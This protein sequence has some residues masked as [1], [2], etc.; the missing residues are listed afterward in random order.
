M[1]R[2]AL[3]LVLIGVLFRFWAAEHA[4][5]TGDE[6]DYW[7]RSL[8]LARLQEIPV[9]GPE[10]TGSEAHLPG[11]AYYYLMAIPQS[12]GVSPRWGAGFVVLLHG[13][14]G[15]L[16]FLVARAARGERAGILGLVLW[17]FAPWDV[18][19][20]DR[21]WGSCV[22]PV[23]GTLA[24]YGALRAKERPAWQGVVL[25]LC[26]VLP[27][28]HL[29][30]PVLWLA[31]LVIVL[32]RRPEKWSKW[33]L[34]VGLALAV[35][36]Y[37]P[38]LSSELR[39]D[40]ANFRTMLAKS[41]GAEP[42]EV[43]KKLPSQ[44][45]GYAVGYASAEI[46]YHFNRGYWGGGF[47]DWA[48]Y[49]SVAGWKK[50]A[51]FHGGW[52]PL[53]AISLLLA[54]WG[55]MAA[56]V[57]TGRQLRQATQDKTPV[58]LEAVLTLAIL[59]G[60]AVGVALM[61]GAK[62]RYF[63]H[64]ANILMPLALWPVV[65]SLD[66][67][68]AKYRWLVGPA[69]AAS[70]LVMV[71]NCIR[72]YTQIDALNGLGPTLAM[73]DRVTQ[74]NGPVNLR[75]SHFYNQY[76]WAMLAENLYRRPLRV[77]ARAPVSFTVNNHAPHDGPIPPGAA[78]F[79]PVL[80]TRTPPQ[81]GLLE[82]AARKNW[83]R[84]KISTGPTGVE[85][86]CVLDGPK[87]RYGAQPWQYFGP[88]NLEIGGETRAILFMHP[89]AGEVVRAQWPVDKNNLRGVLRYGLSDA[90]AQSNNTDPVALHLLQGDRTLARVQAGNNPG[91]HD[92]PFV[93][94]TTAA[95]VLELR[96]QNDGARVF[97]FDLEVEPNP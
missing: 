72:Y 33:S 86:P 36:I 51:N 49:G 5:F 87:C 38:P 69:L 60:L 12:F 32:L 79:G 80:L 61:M 56:L 82:S 91:F 54:L 62:K 17:M 1:R 19:Y 48:A 84:W 40:F 74:E 16:L 85:R 26:L 43:V 96:S 97:A 88:E 27:Q 30:V 10:I 23:W 44:V 18:L 59:V 29:S 77:E 89:I 46:G 75:F 53:L 4:R 52:A 14:C 66:A 94:T 93:L 57:R 7:A 58:R 20:A 64:Y 35:L 22:V 15:F 34:G 90:A 76:A 9:Y 3:F 68:W 2:W 67:A 25:F 71:A 13:L 21:I 47:D 78:T 73:V 28:L 37:L 39:H 63:P 41:G 95:L 65:A 8:R 70:A 45:F 11:P 42:W 83:Q 6:S 50:W 92:I 24:L 55:W 81:G 31:V